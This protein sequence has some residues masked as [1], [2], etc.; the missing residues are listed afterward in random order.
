[1]TGWVRRALA[2]LL[3]VL[4]PLTP[5]L[6]ADLTLRGVAIE[7]NVD[8]DPLPADVP[9]IVPTIVRLSIDRSSNDADTRIARLDQSLTS[10]QS[11]N[12]AVVIALGPVPQS[13]AEVEQW[14]QFIRAVAERARGRVAAFQVGEVR[15]GESPDVS[16]YVYL[17][18][19]AAVQIRSVDP[20]ALVLQGSLPPAEAAWEGRV[21]ASGAQAYVDAFAI[22]DVSANADVE[23]MTAVMR[24]DKISAPILLGPIALP[25][26][27]SGATA[28]FIDSALDLVGTR[29]IG[30][31]SGSPATLKA[32]FAA[33]GDIT[34]LV[35]GDLVPLD[36]KTA[37]LRILR[38]GVEVTSSIRHRL[39]YSVSGFNTY[40]VCWSGEAVDVEI[41]VS[42]APTPMV[43]YPV[44][45]SVQPPEAVER[46]GRQNRMRI[47]MRGSDHPFVVDFNFGNASTYGTSVDVQREALPRVEEI[48]F[49]YQQAQAAQTAALRTY[50]AHVRIEQH[51]HPSPADP[52]YNVITEN[53]LFSDHGVVE[54][55]ELSFE[56]NGAKWTSNRPSF[57]LVQPEK[58]LSL[59]MDL[60]LNEDYTYRLEGVETDRGR[61][62]F[63]V[64]FDPVPSK[65]ARYRGTVW[66]DRQ[67][68]AQLKVH[69]IE[70]QLSGPVVSNDETQIFEP[71]GE[72]D[73]RQVWLPAQLT[74]KQIFLIAGRSVLVERELRLTDFALNPPTFDQ[75]RRAAWASNRVMYRDTEQG[76][77]YLVKSGETR[78]VSDRLTTSARALVM[79]ADIDP[80]LDRPL[81]IAGL[82]I[83]DFNFLN[84]NMQFALL[85][86]GVIA[87]G[88]IQRAN[89]WGGKFDASVDFSG[90]AIKANDDVFDS[91]GKL[92]GERVDKIPVSG[93]LNLGYQLTPFHKVTAHYEIH[94]DAYFRDQT[95]APDFVI[96]SNTAT[97]G[98]G[99]SYEYRRRGYSFL[100]NGFWY[101]RSTWEPWGDGTDYS[102][103]DKTYTR[104]DAGL[105]KDF[106]FKTF[107]TIHLNATY[108]SGQRLDR[109]SMYQS[110]LFDQS[111]LH[112]VPSGVRFAE[113]GMFRGSYSFN[114]FD[115][116]RLDLFVDHA[117]G[118]DPAIDNAWQPVTGT[119]VRLN[120]RA[121]R[122][123]ILQID[124][125]KSF[126]PS[127]YRG[128]GTTVLQILLLKPL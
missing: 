8:A 89:M 22:A 46:L 27:A 95:T 70:T 54:W 68:F 67:T 50:I 33:A 102:A 117:R 124:F 35:G 65:Q 105:S 51:F 108:F 17:L 73:G 6:A 81:P 92:V 56:L 37:G 34:D 76:V 114:I 123:T 53:R 60:R 32:A 84:H 91:Q 18:R 57:P 126:L 25:E 28:R 24:R 47:R 101:Q 122:S 103:S 75:E 113:L 83:L 43:R 16:R 118:R 61:A 55:E 49:R 104:Y 96:P 21:L 15:A 14:R 2:A 100:A 112:G 36:E 128:A 48:I 98:E 120:L 30:V 79:G 20:D 3:F 13:D 94:Y 7:R 9:Q 4:G 52:A 10:Y 116:Y 42:N 41:A 19:L 12:I 87:F 29:T 72:A 23:R 125:G 97:N 106:T 59:P 63:V 71:R 90:I 44:T 110:G 88:N 5:A 58:V 127:A 99:V 74:S 86:G 93:G 39:L 26:D 107:H 77:R 78:V 64:R 111:R 31:F 45:R 1:M 62:A 119:G 85:Y 11:R 38:N 66:I 80:S 69:A 40:L 121:P 115:Q 82:N 109:F